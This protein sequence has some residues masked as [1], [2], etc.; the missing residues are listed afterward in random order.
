MEVNDTEWV[1]PNN[2]MIY[3]GIK[4]VNRTP[5]G[6]GAGGAGSD[7]GSYNGGKG[8][9]GIANSIT[10]AVVYYGGGG[11]HAIDCQSNL[12]TIE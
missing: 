4:F 8:G 1:I 3:Y 5:G 2:F 10:G 7:A 6:G 12:L 9:P 11:K